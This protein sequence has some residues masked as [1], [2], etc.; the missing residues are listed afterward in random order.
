MTKPLALLVT[1]C[2]ALLLPAALNAAV[3]GQ[4]KPDA[5][6][7]MIAAPANHKVVLENERVRVLEATV[8]PHSKEPAHS[9]IWP[10]VLIGYSDG[11]VSWSG[12]RNAQSQRPITPQ[13]PSTTSASS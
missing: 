5:Q 4:V 13:P 3:C 7:A 12:S 10:G 6:D 1:A 2:A 8:L 9:H 11:K